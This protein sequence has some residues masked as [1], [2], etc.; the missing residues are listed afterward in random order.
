[1]GNEQLDNMANARISE[2][3]LRTIRER[4]CKDK[5]GPDYQAAIRADPTEAPGLSTG[6]IL[7]PSKLG[8][9]EFH[10]LSRPETWAALLALYNPAVWDVHEQRILN[11]TPRAHFLFGH[12]RARGLSYPSIRGTV[13][14]AD[15]MGILQKHPKVRIRA[16]DDPTKWQ[17]APYPYVGDLLLFMQDGQGCYVVNW[18]VKDKF[19]SFRRRGPQTQIGK[20]RLDED[21]EGAIARHELEDRYYMDANIR[22]QKVAGQAIDFQLRCNLADLFAADSWSVSVPIELLLLL[23]QYFSD[24]IGS[25]MLANQVVRAAAIKFK[26]TNEIALTVLRQGIWRRKIRV[27]LFRPFLMD[28][29]LWPEVTD[30]LA[31]YSKWFTRGG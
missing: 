25:E 8:G 14:V 12:E 15:S 31:Y 28:K 7:R 9:R 21:D 23:F 29:P 30:A 18:T 13:E 3:R 22:T 1:M 4:Q 20:P 11:P 17:Y 2:S 26:T 19:K 16:G 5:W 24:H 10:T 27:D 6:S